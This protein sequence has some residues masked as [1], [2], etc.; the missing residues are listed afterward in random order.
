[1]AVAKA[2]GAGFPVAATLA[3]ERAASAMTPGSHGSTFGGNPLA[4]AVAG[5]AF[6]LIAER[7]LL[8]RVIAV[9]AQLR[10]GLAAL[11]ARYP[12]LVQEVRG[13]GLLIGIKVTPLNREV[14]AAA[15]R[16]SLLIAGG[17]DNV[18]RLL[19]P[20]TLTDADAR[21]VLARLDRTFAAMAAPA[22]AA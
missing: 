19:P 5:T 2:L 20:L 11:Q 8:A 9:E 12:E 18:V 10:D 1:M 3:T 16:E 17:G 6:D 14:I 4:M 7:T 13:K 21:E 22:L 15:R